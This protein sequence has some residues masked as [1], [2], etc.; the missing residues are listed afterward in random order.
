MRQVAVDK[1][2]E[3]FHRFALANGLNEARAMLYMI[4]ETLTLNQK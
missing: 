3:I 2:V 1:M 4:K